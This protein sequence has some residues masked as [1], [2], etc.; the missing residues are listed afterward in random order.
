MLLGLEKDTVLGAHHQLTIQLELPIMSWV[1]SDPPNQKVQW[2][3]EQ[4]TIK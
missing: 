3:Q 1:L 4:S 2:V